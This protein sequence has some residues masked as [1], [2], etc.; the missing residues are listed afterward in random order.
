MVG[1]FASGFDP[2]KDLPPLT[3]K[4]MLVTGGN[5]GVG[6]ATVKHLARCGAKVYLAARN[7]IKG[8]NAVARLEAEGLGPGNGSVVFLKLDLSHPRQAKDA[9]VEFMA[10]EDRL[11]VLV[12]NAGA[13]VVNYA[14]THD[15]IQDSVMINYISPFVFTTTLLPLLIRTAKQSGSDVRIVNVSSDGHRYVQTPVH[16]RNLDDFNLEFKG[17]ILSRLRRYFLSK[18]A[19]MLFSAELQ[20]RLNAD[21]IPITVIA[22]HP[23]AVNA[24]WSAHTPFPKLVAWLASWIMLHPDQGAYTSTIAA[25][26]KDVIENPEK[27]KNAYLI[28]FGQ[29]GTPSAT[30]QDPE[31]AAELWNTTEGFVA[32]ISL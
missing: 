29:L 11:D 24:G 30:S 20:R 9:A 19:F 26:S 32:S 16:F 22:V 13:M 28:P 3:G 21:D 17:K 4:V 23:G 1:L 2:V 31:L 12:N 25:A 10:L 18:L 14:I 5:T 8:K 27:Y 6:Y 7:E 15:G